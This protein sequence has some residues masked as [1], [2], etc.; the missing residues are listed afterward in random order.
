[1]VQLRR[2]LLLFMCC[3]SV[4]SMIQVPISPRTL[5]QLRRR[6]SILHSKSISS[7][8]SSDTEDFE[9]IEGNHDESSPEPFVLVNLRRPE[10]PQEL[11]PPGSLESVDL[12]EYEIMNI[13]QEGCRDC[14]T[15]KSCFECVLSKEDM[16]D[17]MKPLDET[18]EDPLDVKSNDDD[19]SFEP[20]EGCF[21][22][23]LPDN[24][25][26]DAIFDAVERCFGKNCFGST[27][28]DQVQDAIE[29][30]K[31]KFDLHSLSNYEDKVTG[32]K[33]RNVSAKRGE[34]DRHIKRNV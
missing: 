2:L 3:Y 17:A 24:D 30:A 32:R 23:H 18:R 11:K 14:Q 31:L 26:D 6:G 7:S 9:I 16:S 15:A 20:V 21:G 12:E 13:A 27:L 19:V 25:D 33:K 34:A 5:G 28:A 29:E 10:E 22:C 1:M 4:H 8:S